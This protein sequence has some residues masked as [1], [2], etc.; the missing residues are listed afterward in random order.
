MTEQ[1]VNLYF[2]SFDDNEKT[3]FVFQ[4]SV[5]IMLLII[6][7]LLIDNKKTENNG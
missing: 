3:K 6:D 5:K 4:V 7:L 1:N 2:Q